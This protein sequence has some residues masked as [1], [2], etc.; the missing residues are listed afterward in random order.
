MYLGRYG[1]VRN[2]WYNVE[3][4]GVL[5]IGSP[6]IPDPDDTK[7]D[8]EPEPENYLDVK[9]NVVAWQKRNQSNWLQ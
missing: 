3:V 8:D 9:I 4:S 2:N 5:N 6:V 1:V 7:W